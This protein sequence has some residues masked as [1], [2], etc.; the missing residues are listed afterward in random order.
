MV[1]AYRLKKLAAE[2][3]L[4]VFFVHIFYSGVTLKVTE[5]YTF[6][7]RFGPEMKKRQLFKNFLIFLIDKINQ[8]ES[9]LYNLLS[10]SLNYYSDI[11]AIL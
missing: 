6:L 8:K 9:L 7:E 4:T 5:N 11:S 3:R 1:P 10:S 2:R